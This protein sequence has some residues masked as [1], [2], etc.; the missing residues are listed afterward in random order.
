MI[1]NFSFEFAF[2]YIVWIHN[3]TLGTEQ[4]KKVLYTYSSYWYNTISLKQILLSLTF[5]VYIN[6]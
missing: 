1:G 6:I 4:V 3:R 5:F 2:I